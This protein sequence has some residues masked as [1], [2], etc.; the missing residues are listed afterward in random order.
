MT[1][2]TERHRERGVA[3]GQDQGECG[4]EEVVIVGGH[5]PGPT[6]SGRLVILAAIGSA[7][8]ETYTLRRAASARLVPG[9]I[10]QRWGFIY[11]AAY[12]YELVNPPQ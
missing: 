3:L 6:Q 5:T 11:E 9:Q 8:A 7:R 10:E 12:V 4:L 2:R 1:P